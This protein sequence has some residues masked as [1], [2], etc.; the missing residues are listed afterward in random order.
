VN[1]GRDS[2]GRF[3]GG[4]RINCE[5]IPRLRAASVRFAVED[6]RRIPFVFL[7][8]DRWEQPLEAAVVVRDRSAEETV[9]V[10][11]EHDGGHV[12]RAARHPRGDRQR[13]T[14]PRPVKRR[15]GASLIEFS[16]KTSRMTRRVMTVRARVLRVLVLQNASDGPVVTTPT[17]CR[18]REAPVTIAVALV[19]LISTLFPADSSAGVNRWTTSGP[20]VGNVKALAIDPSAP[21]TLYAG[22]DGGVFKSINGGQSWTAINSG[23]TDT[24]VDALAIDP[25]APATLY[26][27]TNLG[28]VFK[29]TNAGQSWTAVNV[30]LTNTR[31]QALA[32]D[33]SAPATLY[34]GTFGIVSGGVFKSSNGGQSWTAVGGLADYLIDVLAIDPSAPATLYAGAGGGVFKSTNGGQSWTAINSGLTH[35]LPTVR[36]LAIDPSAPATLYAG[37]AGPGVSLGVVSGG[38]FKS[39]NA[40]QSWTAVNV[41]LPGT[42]VFALAIDPSAPATLYAG[43]YGGVFK[44]TN[45]GQSWTAVNV[46]LIGTAVQVLALDPSAPVTLYAGTYGGGTF[47]SSNGGQ[48]W[49]AVSAGLTDTSV[50][51]LAID[52][53]A[54]TTLYAGTLYGVFKSSNAGQSWTAVNAGLTGPYGN[55]QEVFALAIDPSAPAT[56]Y[57]GGNGIFKSSNAGQSWTAINSGLTDTSV[58]ALAIDPSAPATLYA[59]TPYGAFRSSNGGLSWTAVN[60]G[61]TGPYGNIQEVF[62]LAI[63]PSAPATLYAG[64]YGGVF[65][66]TNAGQ[67]WTAVNVGLTN[68]RVTALAIDPLAP[69]TLYAGTQSGGVFKSSNGGQRWTAV[70][71][72][73][74]STLVNALAIDPSAPAT[75]YVGTDGGGVFK[76][77]NGGQ[78][79]TAFNAGLTNTSVLALAIDPSAPALYAGTRGG[80]VFDYEGPAPCASGPM[81]L[82]L[83]NGRFKVTALWTTPDGQT[84]AGQAVNLTSDTGYFWF[85][86]SNNVEMVTKVVDGRGFNS[87]FW[88]FAGG[89]TN[90]NVVMTVTDTQTGAVK[91]YTNPQGTAFQPIQ[92]TSAFAAST[93]TESSEMALAD[94]SDAQAASEEGVQDSTWP[95]RPI[96]PSQSPFSQARAAQAPCVADATTLCLNN[97]RFRLQAQWTTVQGQSGAGQAVVLTGD[98]GY[99][100]FFSSNN[101][102]LV[103]KALNACGQP[104]GRFWVFAGG[105]T[106]VNV[107]MTVTDTQTGAV[108]TYTNPQGTAF[109]PIQDTSAFATC[110]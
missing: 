91:T 88:V 108:K 109:Q 54:P 95:D 13:I 4:R 34:A 23:L 60:A 11:R 105:L 26:A 31:V 85:F 17:R 78:S 55:I 38:V 59:G 27:G 81:T 97:S 37:T 74:A 96:S 41:G 64:T 101:I 36:A 14:V 69:A 15:A 102:E 72:G 28:G 100:W 44:S 22:T 104:P 68:T 43:T 62:A 8:R 92:D 86:S 24:I 93:T 6:P 94:A 50:Q 57:A 42:V 71:S 39:T 107:V 65:K 90:V 46:G 87:R 45:G 56:L 106:N 1:N 5:S 73:L 7:W 16:F 12:R 30:G 48:S 33:P 51:A 103:V 21:A 79:W 63:D 99:F 75:L 70:N 9:E 20:D 61:L 35:P 53:S 10:I 52:P 67:S 19:A 58:Q 110:P 40:G 3:Y 18:R 25:S 83:N 98:T 29:S 84:G 76:S 89:L 32:I 66:S 47:R 82:C 49:T 80:G 2:D 77:T